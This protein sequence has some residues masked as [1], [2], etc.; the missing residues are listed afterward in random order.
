MTDA[1]LA[2]WGALDVAIIA[3]RKAAE[4]RDVDTTSLAFEVAEEAM[5]KLV[6]GEARATDAD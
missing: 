1:E 2:R 5:S 3:L 6:I 4:S